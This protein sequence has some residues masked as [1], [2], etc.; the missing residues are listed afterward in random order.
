M[1]MKLV[2]IG[3]VLTLLLAACSALA[4][5]PDAA[6]QGV[7]FRHSVTGTSQTNSVSTTGAPSGSSAN[8][9]EQ[10]V[11]AAITKVEPAVV[12]ITVTLSNGEALGSGSI[13]TSDGYILTNDHVVQGGQ[14][15]QVQTTMAQYPAS[16]AGTDPADDLALLKISAAQPLPTITFADSAKAQVGEFVI[17]EGNPLG[18][19]QSASFGIVSALNRTVS[20]AP[21]GPA[22]T[23][24]NTIQTSAPINHGNSGGALIDLA[25]NLIGIPT[26]GAVDPASGATAAGIGFAIPANHANFIAQQIIAHGTVA[27]TGRAYLGIAPVDVTPDIA[28]LN[29][30]ALS[31]GAYIQQ[32]IGGGPAQSAG[33]QPGDIIYQIDAIPINDTTG[34]GAYLATKEPGDTVMVAANR[35]GQNVHLRVILGTL[36]AQ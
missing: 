27:N 34:L 6:S 26:L 2:I 29:H 33:L 18:V 32:V 4:A 30:L 20:E 35:N 22:N 13:I 24:P 16:L 31:H 10:A 36:P 7:S 1:R 28:A 5:A 8:T 3:G 11:V 21:D 9:L 14:S 25:G 19:G 17:A 12:E 23:I 15:Y